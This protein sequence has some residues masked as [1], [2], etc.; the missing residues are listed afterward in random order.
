[1]PTRPELS[2]VTALYLAPILER[3]SRN[4]AS[5]ICELFDYTCTTL[6]R[7][8]V[9]IT[10]RCGHLNEDDAGIITTLRQG[11]SKL[12]NLEELVIVQNALLL[13][14]T[15]TVDH[16]ASWR[17]FRKLRRLAVYQAYASPQFW[18]D[19]A[20]MPQL[21]TVVLTRAEGLK[22]TNI[23]TNYFQHADRPLKVLLID[24][25][26]DQIRFSAMRRERWDAVDPHKKMTVMTYNIPMF[27][28]DDPR[29]VCRDYVRTGAEYGTLWDWEGEVI[30]HPPRIVQLVS[31]GA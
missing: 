14:T 13:R 24:G 4:V 22:H 15:V 12:E 20:K 11:F 30:Q 29:Q 31:S 8:I 28:N 1:M 16:Y 10:L 5:W 6:K 3:N 7:L 19:V 2:K 21:E 25:E 17:R 9:D 26:D 18:E 23:K 27:M